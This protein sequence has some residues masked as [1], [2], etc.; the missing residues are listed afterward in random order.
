MSTILN[1]LNKASKDRSDSA[2]PPQPPQPPA[3]PEK[4]GDKPPPPERRQKISRSSFMFIVYSLSLIFIIVIIVIAKNLLSPQSIVERDQGKKPGGVSISDE[5]RDNLPAII[6]ERPR[7]EATI[8]PIPKTLVKIDLSEIERQRKEI[9]SETQKAERIDRNLKAIEPTPQITPVPQ[10]PTPLKPP[11]KSKLPEKKVSQVSKVEKQ[12][13]K[14]VTPIPS[15]SKSLIH[16]SQSAVTPSPSPTPSPTP[17][18]VPSPSPTPAL[19]PTPA[20]TPTVLLTP[21]PLPAPTLSPQPAL[22]PANSPTPQ[23]E[24]KTAEQKPIETPSPEIEKIGASELKLT[25][26]GIMYDTNQPM[27]VINDKILG[28]DEKIEGYK[29]IKIEKTFIVIEKDGKQYQISPGS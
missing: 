19:T 1:A 14:P 5:Q 27:V 6:V 24:S 29:I 8:T 20:P 18:P 21:T 3:P 25:F 22:T 15:P 16:P 11:T 9:V 12:T 4:P 7:L 17:T 28:L 13:P 23:P 10:K 2:K 26:E